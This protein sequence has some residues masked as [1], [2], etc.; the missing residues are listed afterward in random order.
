MAEYPAGGAAAQQV[1]V[2]DAVPTRQHRVDQ[3]QQLGA[4]PVRAGP[5]A[6]VDQRIAACSIPSRWAR[7]AGAA[8]PLG[9]GV[10]VVEAGVE[11]VEGV[12]GL[13]ENMPF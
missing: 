2:V 13:L 8:G 10:G 3:G 7:M 4:R 5:L 9:D 11:L 6:Q 1:G 12:G